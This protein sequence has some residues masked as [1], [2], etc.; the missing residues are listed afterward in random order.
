MNALRDRIVT[1]HQDLTAAVLWS[2]IIYGLKAGAE[3]AGRHARAEVESM[4]PLAPWVG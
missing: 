1:V 3:L 4:E 2:E